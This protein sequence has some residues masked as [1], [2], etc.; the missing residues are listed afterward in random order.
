MNTAEPGATAWTSSE[1]ATIDRA[2][3]IQVATRRADGSPRTARIV[4]V[5]RHGDALYVRSVN[6]VDAAWYRGVQS[7]HT[8]VVTIGRVGHEVAFVEAGDHAGTTPA[9]TTRSTRPTG[10][11]T[12]GRPL[13]SS[14]SPRSPRARPPCASTRLKS[15]GSKERHGQ[16]PHQHD[17]QDTGSRTSPATSG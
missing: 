2:T 16:E 3:E 13:R 6:G 4:W 1:L 11:S 10:P 12:A 7:R 5:V 14:G 8:G 9:W 15:P 17:G